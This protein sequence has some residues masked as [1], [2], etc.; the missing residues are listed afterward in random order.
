MGG[1]WG[2]DLWKGRVE[3]KG[4]CDEGPGL[5]G[6]FLLGSTFGR[7]LPRFSNRHALFER[8]EH[9]AYISPGSDNSKKRLYC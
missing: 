4:R 3:G 6:S 9:T 7:C 1:E 2:W 5:G 8:A